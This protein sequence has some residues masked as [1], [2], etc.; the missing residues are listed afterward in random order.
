[1]LAVAA[2]LSVFVGNAARAAV[3]PED[4][5]AAL[6]AAYAKYA[7][8]GSPLSEADR[9]LACSDLKS[10]LRAL[11]AL[12]RQA[13]ANGQR[14]AIAPVSNKI[15]ALLVSEC[16]EQTVLPCGGPHDSIVLDIR[17]LLDAKLIEAGGP[18]PSVLETWYGAVS[19]I[20]GRFDIAFA[21]TTS[22]VHVDWA[23]CRQPISLQVSV[24]AKLSDFQ[25]ERINGRLFLTAHGSGQ[26]QIANYQ[27][28]IR[29]EAGDGAAPKAAASSAPMRFR[30]RLDALRVDPDNFELTRAFF[31]DL[32]PGKVNMTWDVWAIGGRRTVSYEWWHEM[33]EAHFKGLAGGDGNFVFL[34]GSGVSSRTIATDVFNGAGSYDTYGKWSGTDAAAITIERAD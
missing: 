4:A 33:F 30:V 12:S 28:S 9:K 5:A 31:V 8:L 3:T 29:C 24:R 6:A 13:E 2:V 18:D 16:R 11:A 10:G 14:L 7:A 26:H 34:L 27:H 22:G 32:L 19:R 1:M 15:L 25:F 21:T 23:S 17:Y 20:C